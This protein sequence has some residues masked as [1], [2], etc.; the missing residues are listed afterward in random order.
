VPPSSFRVLLIGAGHAHLHV[1]SHAEELAKEGIH[2]TLID[3]GK[4]WYSG[5]AAGMLS[6]DYTPEQTCL[7][8]HEVLAR[9]NGAVL[10]AS[11]VALSPESKT[12]HLSTGETKTYDLLSLN[13]GSEVRIP[14]PVESD[15]VLP[16]KPLSALPTLL[17]RIRADLPSTVPIRMVILG[18]GATGCEIAAT[19]A[20]VCKQ[21][22]VPVHLTLLTRSE[23]VIPEMP[24]AASQRMVGVLNRLGVNVLLEREIERIEQDTAHIQGAENV[25][26]DLFLAATGLR[27]NALLQDL[28]LETGPTGGV[29]V[30]ATLQSVS[31]PSVFAVGDCADFAP[32]P[33]PRLGVYGVRQGP[34]LLENIRRQKN[35]T[36]LQQYH[37]QKRALQILQTGKQRGLFVYG[38]LVFEGRT[39]FRIKSWIDR[40][41][42]AQYR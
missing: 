21:Q 1:A 14:F 15:R 29:R 23:R 39:A 37:P 34:V 32:R 6:G 35:G 38:P 36:T 11:L 7:A 3:P 10:E 42:L 27:P 18:G 12:V 5:M 17:P 9:G 41:F 30:G 4:F 40:R 8:P 26:A 13:I 31:D 2:L 24:P 20:V 25:S 16:V 19:L 33:L 22:D 28:P